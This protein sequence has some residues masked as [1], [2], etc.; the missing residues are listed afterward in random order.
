MN[1]P[2]QLFGDAPATGDVPHIPHTPHVPYD[3]DLPALAELNW[4]ALYEELNENGVALTPPLLSHAQCR[5]IIGTFDDAAMFR[6]VVVMQRYNFGRGTY[7]YYANPLP[8]LVR[9][10]R[11][12][13]YPP[14]AWIAN[15]WAPMLGERAFPETLEELTEECAAN[16]Q[17]RPTPLILNYGEGDY[18]CLH[19]DIYGDVVFP[20]QI[21]IML[22]RPGEDFTG[23]ENVFVEQRPRFQSK[24][25]VV[26]PELGQGMIFPVRHRPIPGKNGYRRHPMRHGTNAVESG[27]RNTLGV[28]FHNA[29]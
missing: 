7:K 28:I 14:L 6:S 22:N 29:R 1:H 19:Q 21:A 15:Q 27:Q 16:G 12:K 23:G 4:P 13:L 5:Q 11:E 26:K 24:A 9:A 18:A 8:P 17:H 3:K 25:I 2:A 20:L 10:L